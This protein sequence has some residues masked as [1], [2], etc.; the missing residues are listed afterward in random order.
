MLAFG[1]NCAPIAWCERNALDPLVGIQRAHIAL[2]IRHLGQSG[3]MDSVAMAAALA[4]APRAAL[5]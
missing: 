2:Y 1:P 4:T 3:L 5:R